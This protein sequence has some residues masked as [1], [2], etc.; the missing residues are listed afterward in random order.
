VYQESMI[1]AY[2]LSCILRHNTYTQAELAYRKKI[3]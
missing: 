1:K 2:Y 3:K